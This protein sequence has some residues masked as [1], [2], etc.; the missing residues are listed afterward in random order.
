MRNGTIA[1]TLAVAALVAAPAA[2]P[3]QVPPPDSAWLVTTTQR[4]LN[5]ITAGDSD[6][7]APQLAPP[8]FVTTEEG[9]HL[10]RATFL[11][12]LR[13][14]PA[15]QQGKLTLNNVHLVGNAGTAV[16][17]YDAD[18]EHNYYG[19]VLL[20]RFHST[21]TWVRS[22]GRWEQLASQTTALPRQVDGR[23]VP[24]GVR[25]AY[26]GTYRLA[27]DLTLA[28]IASDSGLAMV[29]DRTNWHLYALDDRT[30]IR[31]SIRGFWIFQ[32]DS[33]GT[34]TG[35]VNWRD[36]NAIVWTRMP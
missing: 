29:R 15:G 3:A 8:W 9:V 22:Q 16:V 12:S 34:V 30:F 13:P 27:P 18:E 25:D 31:H 7:W 19:Q 36:N 17:S 32:R 21:D 10:P 11:A 26:V 5:A 35:L 2:L 24:A 33:T 20:T 6:I 1:G 14:L 28:V 23:A 4:M